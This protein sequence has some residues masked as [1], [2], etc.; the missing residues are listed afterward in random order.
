MC[1]GG[2]GEGEDAAREEHEQRSRRAP[3]G[4]QAACNAHTMHMPCIH[5]ACALC[6]CMYDAY[7]MHAT[8]WPA[9]PW[10]EPEQAACN[11]WGAACNPWGGRLERIGCMEPPPVAEHEAAACT[12]WGGRGGRPPAHENRPS[13][14]IRAAAAAAALS[15]K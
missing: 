7:T 4:E 5:R 15:P 2:D 10:H 8:P 6:M 14:K 3:E 1:C 13:A 9:T 11:Q 12:A